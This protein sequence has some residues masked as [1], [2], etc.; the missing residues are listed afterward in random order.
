MKFIGFSKDRKSATFEIKLKPGTHYQ[1]IANG[2]FR[3]DNGISLKPYLI[4]FQTV[5]KKR[6]G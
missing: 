6:G 3:S 5:N 4:D 1:S 2:Y